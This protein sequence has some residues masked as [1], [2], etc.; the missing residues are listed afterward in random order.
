VAGNLDRKKCVK[1]KA[2]SLANK[3][4]DQIIPWERI[5]PHK[6]VIRLRDKKYFFLFPHT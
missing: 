5:C 3:I 1:R 2:V 4:F 6:F